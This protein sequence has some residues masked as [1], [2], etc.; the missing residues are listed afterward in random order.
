M[1]NKVQNSLE[2]LEYIVYI[3]N[4]QIVNLH[5]HKK[6]SKSVKWMYKLS[7]VVLKK[8]DGREREG[9]FID[10]LYLRYQFFSQ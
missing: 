3:S 2:V 9:G 10:V 4:C 8:E 5:R 7:S 6:L 1:D